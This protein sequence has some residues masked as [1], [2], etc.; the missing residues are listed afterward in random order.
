M[1]ARVGLR[2]IAACLA[3]ASGAA[4]ATDCQ[5]TTEVV[6]R[7]RA[8]SCAEVGS[9]TITVG[10]VESVEKRPPIASRRGCDASSGEI[11]TL[12]LTPSGADDAEVAVKVVTGIGASAES[13]AP[14]AYRG[15]VVARRLVRYTPGESRVVEI[16][17]EPECKDVL[18][19]PGA[20]CREG[21]CVAIVD[22][23]A[24][25]GGAEGGATDA[26]AGVDAAPVRC[27]DVCDGG[28]S[29]AGLCTLTCS[30]ANAC[31]NGVRCP[32]GVPCK[33][34]CTS[35]D[36]CKGTIDCAGA[37]S[38]EVDCD[39]DRTCGN[40]ICNTPGACKIDCTRPDT[41][42][43]SVTC[44]AASGCTIDCDGDRACKGAVRCASTSCNVTCT[45]N[46][47]CNAGV[48]AEAGS[49]MIA[50]D[51]DDNTCAGNIH[52]S[53][54]SCTG[55]CMKASCNNEFCCD[56]GSC[57]RGNFTACGN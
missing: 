35:N 55:N 30:G 17:I 8:T 21:R 6:L 14:P 13:C 2:W 1:R 24:V 31:P 33:I 47:A 41:C 52:C 4:W 19:D 20:T 56:A 5:K 42:S 23:G 49:S 44:T 36:S 54:G 29:D 37:T 12:T 46:G 38:C 18:C 43:G 11:G 10:T 40:V 57:S 53:G 45:R 32:P 26:E 16:T 3:V 7:V 50:C 27:Q 22:G 34:Q 25:D 15:C 51:G 48:F 9:T 28:C 39:G